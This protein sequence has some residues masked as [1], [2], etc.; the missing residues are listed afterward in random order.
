M[1]LLPLEFKIMTMDK[2]IYNTGWDGDIVIKAN[3]QEDF[4]ILLNLVFFCCLTL[5]FLR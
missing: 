3:T 1:E 5:R 2:A 4:Q